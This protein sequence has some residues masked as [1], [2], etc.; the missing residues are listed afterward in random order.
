VRKGLARQRAHGGDE[1][2]RGR[3]SC[4]TRRK[5]V[6][7]LMSF[8]FDRA[9]TEGFVLH[10]EVKLNMFRIMSTGLND[11]DRVFVKGLV[12]AKRN[13]FNYWGR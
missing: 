6:E 8:W 7:L 2:D 10:G 9:A 12:V 11:S 13:V 1:G 3:S 4:P 5:V